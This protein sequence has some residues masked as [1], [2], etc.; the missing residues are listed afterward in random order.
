MVKPKN[1]PLS[2]MRHSAAHVLAAAVLRLYPK[3]KLGIG[4][5]IENGFY[6]DFEFEKPLSKEDLPKIEK[7][8]A[9]VVKSNFPFIKK[10]ASLVEA[11]KL[12]KNQPYKQ[13]LIKD[14]E[15]RGGAKLFLSI[16]A[17]IL[18]IFAPD[19]MF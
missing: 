5:A 18:P 1:D 6:Y 10:T 11:K 8:M 19:L 16:K 15:S 4:P 14:L 12:F 3:T 7:E 2:T 17:V 13:K 9:K